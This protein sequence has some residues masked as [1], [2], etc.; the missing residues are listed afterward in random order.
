MN[1]DLQNLKKLKQQ[2]K[3]KPKT[4]EEIVGTHIEKRLRKLENSSSSNNLPWI[5]LIKHKGETTEELFKEAGHPG[6]LSDY[7][8]FLIQIVDTL[9]RGGVTGALTSSSF[10]IGGF[11]S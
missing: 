3:I 1:H 7:R 2:I 4:K 8:V 9:P 10:D 11:D 6:Q 5:R